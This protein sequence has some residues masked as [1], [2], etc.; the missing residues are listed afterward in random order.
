MT[1]ALV[2][3]AATGGRIRDFAPY[4]ASIDDRGLVAFQAALAGG[5]TGVFAGDGA[6][7]LAG[8]GT[9][10]FSDGGQALSPIA[11]R[12]TGL[13]AHVRSHPDVA[14]DGACCFYADLASGEEAVL[15]VRGDRTIR[16]ASTKG[17]FRSVGPLGPTIGDGGEVAFRADLRS[18]QSGI[19]TGDG[20]GEPVPVALTGARFHAFAGLPVLHGRGDIVFRASLSGGGQGIYVARG[21][22]LITVV[23]TGALFTDLGLFPAANDAG[24]VVF[25]GS[26]AGRGGVHLWTDGEL[27]PVIEAGAVAPGAPGPFESFRGALLDG[28]GGVIFYATPRGGDLGVYALPSPSA[29]GSADEADEIEKILAIGDPLF[30]STVA[31]FALNPV[32]VNRAGQA[33]IRVALADGSQAIVRADMP[34]ARGRTQPG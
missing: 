15:L 30:G 23:E 20:A 12:S 11:D 13:D 33:A 22:S 21:A 6:A 2:R 17:P 4:V 29:S 31:A 10:V 16:V 8:G 1:P 34:L 32:S 19:F 25:A 27:T 24:A 5:G 7:M 3:I 26:R 9:G 14:P 28:A 18:G